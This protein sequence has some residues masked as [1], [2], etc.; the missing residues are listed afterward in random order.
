MVICFVGHSTISSGEQ[1]KEIVKDQIRK[2]TVNGESVICYLGCRG[3]F[4]AISALACRELKK[5]RGNMELVYVAPY[6]NSA[7]QDKIKDM[8]EAGLYDSSIYPPIENTPL[9]FAILK[10]NEWMVANADLVIAYVR[11]SWGGA[12]RSLDFAKRRKKK[13]IN[14]CELK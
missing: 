9:K 11:H 13:T 7:E 8:Y 5:E 4:D 3:D 6:L 14:I 12:H 2:N 1:I 10:R